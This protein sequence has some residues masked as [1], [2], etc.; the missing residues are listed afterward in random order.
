M[1]ESHPT[2]F[3]WITV[4][5]I[6]IGPVFALFAQRVL[7]WMREK[8]QRRVQLYQIAMALRGTWLHPDS[9]RALNSIDTIFDKKKDQKIRDAWA[10]VIKHACT[11]MPNAN[12]HPDENRA[13]LDR[14]WDLRVDLY[15]VLGT[16]VGYDHTIDY[17]KNQL[18]VPQGYVDAEIEGI[19]IRKQFAKAITDDGLKVLVKNQE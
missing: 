11:L 13:W 1:T 16:A 2:W 6:F 5:A 4:A 15:Q 9:V 19:L 10:A 8:K 3:D 18:Y 7:D 17:I 14:L 12:T